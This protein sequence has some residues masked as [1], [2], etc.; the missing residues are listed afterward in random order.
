MGEKISCT[1]ESSSLQVVVP[2]KYKELVMKVAHESLLSGHLGI[3]VRSLCYS[4]DTRVYT[5]EG[6]IPLVAL[7]Y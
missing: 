7:G 6:S 5:L 1:G 3:V 4:G 2:I